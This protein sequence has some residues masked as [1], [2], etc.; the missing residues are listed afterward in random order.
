MS[1]YGHWI[2]VAPEKT[3]LLEWR[4]DD[5]GTRMLGNLGVRAQ[6]VPHTKDSLAYRIEVSNGRAVVCSTSIPR[7]LPWTL[8]LDAAGHSRVISSW[9]ATFRRSVYEPEHRFGAR[10]RLVIDPAR[11]GCALRLMRVSPVGL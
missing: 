6:R 2:R 9:A 4:I 7:C 10:S 11:R 3:A 1:S 5:G 8:P